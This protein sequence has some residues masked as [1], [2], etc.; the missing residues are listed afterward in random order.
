MAATDSQ[1]PVLTT[2]PV[3]TETTVTPAVEPSTAAPA[4]VDAP[5]AEVTSSELEAPAQAVDAAASSEPTKPQ[6]KRSPFSD[7]KNKLFA[8][9]VSSLSLAPCCPSRPLHAR[10]R[11]VGPGGQ[12]FPEGVGG[13]EDGLEGVLQSYRT[14]CDPTAPSQGRLTR[15]LPPSRVVSHLGA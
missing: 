8:G 10:M 5:A 9:K 13:L 6:I 15:T 14:S 4:T 1:T 7:M 3:L 12:F 11:S 2:E